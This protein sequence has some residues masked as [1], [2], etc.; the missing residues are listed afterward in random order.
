MAARGARAQ[1]GERVRR[2]GTLY[3]FLADD[4]EGQAR[5]VSAGAAAVGL[6]RRGRRAEHARRVVLLIPLAES[7]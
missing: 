4:P 1:Q 6:D 3:T 5:N 7:D 2:I